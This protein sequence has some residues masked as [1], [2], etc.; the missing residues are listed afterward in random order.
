[1]WSDYADGRAEPGVSAV[2]VH[3]LHRGA[4]EAVPAIDRLWLDELPEEPPG[5]R[6]FD[7]S[8]RTI[9]AAHGLPIQSDDTRHYELPPCVPATLDAYPSGTPWQR[10]RALRW[11]ERLLGRSDP[12]AEIVG[13]DRD[14]WT[15]AELLLAF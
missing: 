12:A 4:R 9:R 13:D 7:C 15:A 6:D 5:P 1:R 2:A 8:N 14:A 11:L 10:L 3:A